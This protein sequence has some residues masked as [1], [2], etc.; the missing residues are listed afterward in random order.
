MDEQTR[1]E[2]ILLG[3]MIDNLNQMDI[4]ILNVQM[5]MFI[6]T[7]IVG[8]IQNGAVRTLSA[9]FMRERI[10]ICL[11]Q[12][13]RGMRLRDIMNESFVGGSILYTSQIAK[14]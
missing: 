6:Y 13:M 7:D 8:S 14:M 3:I 4:L 9:F 1:T 5:R 11:T 10:R 2:H 12:E